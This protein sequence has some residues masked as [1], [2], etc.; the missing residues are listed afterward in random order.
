MEN[1]QKI[2][3][4]GLWAWTVGCGALVGA[5][6]TDIAHNWRAS[7]P[8]EVPTQQTTAILHVPYTPVGTFPMDI[9]FRIVS[10]AEFEKI[11][12]SANTVAFSY[13]GRS[14]RKCEIVIPS[15]DDVFAFTPDQR[16]YWLN[17]SYSDS[18]AHE[19]LHCLIGRWHG[20]RK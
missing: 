19:L 14:G 20:E 13:M 1:P 5:G 7:A 8:R 18:V 9:D 6:I 2:A 17:S 4:I 3:I 11:R 15:R 16:V 10:V 12:P